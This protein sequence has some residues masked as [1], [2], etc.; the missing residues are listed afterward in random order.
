MIYVGIALAAV[1]VFVLLFVILPGLALIHDHQVGVV[2]KKMFGKKM[3]EGQIVA[4]N[5]EIGI[6]AHTL[7]PGLYWRMPFLWKIQKVDVTDIGPDEVGVVESIDGIPITAGRLLGNDVDCN[8]FQDAKAFLDNGGM[9]GPQVGILRPGTY[10]INTKVFTVTKQPVTKVPKEKVGIVVAL[11]GTPLPSGYIVAPKPLEYKVA[12]APETEK[13]RP[14]KFFQDGQAFLESCGYRGPQLDTLQPGEYYINPLLFRV[15]LFDVFEV[16]PGYVAV[17]R[18]NVGKE[19]EQSTKTPAPTSMAPNFRQ[20]V[21]EKEEVV[22]I[23]DRDTRGIWNQPV[24]PGKY[25]LN[26]IAFTPYIVPTSAVT[27]D[28]AA[29]TSIRATHESPIEDDRAYHRRDLAVVGDDKSNEFF[30]FAQLKVTS[31]DGFELEVDVRIVIRIRPE[32]AA[33]VIARFGSIKN[34]IEQIVH[35]LIDSSFRNNAGAKK[36]IEFVRSRTS[37]Q[38]E[39]LEKA[40]EE[41]K[42]YNV[43]AQNLLIAYI[44]VDKELLATQTKKEI[45]LQ[46]QEQY[47]EETRAETERI[48]VQE[49]K[50]RADR[51]TD[52]VAALL[53]IDIAKNRADATRQEADGDRDA[54]KSRAD[55]VAHQQRQIGQANADAYTAQAEALGS[56]GAALLQALERIASGEVKITPDVLVTGGGEGGQ[57]GNLLTAWLADSL[58]RTQ[59]PSSAARE[60]SSSR[61][62]KSTASATAKSAAKAGEAPAEALSS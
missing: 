19:L 33:F 44:K 38:G 53:S 29:G 41:F 10:R 52:V 15:D 11:D 22:L 48:A 56:S 1:A 35:P 51:Q 12:N 46:Q 30:T 62:G 61:K 9:K 20:P 6:Q 27:I 43:E 47:Q 28:W 45:A 40:R 36:A 37:L 59:E 25:N 3:P 13:A 50:A 57:S 42:Y 21:H 34:L 14:H 32:N 23:L 16:P 2:T 18:S 54:T 8:S 39:A 7:M 4:R 24:A 58:R 49:Q 31:Q 26:P 5:G 55:G 60:A 17:L